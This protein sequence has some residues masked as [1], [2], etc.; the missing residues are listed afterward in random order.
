M[1]KN[2]FFESKG[3][4]KLNILFPKYSNSEIK[5]NDIKK[6]LSEASG[7]LIPGGFGKRGTEGKIAAI[8]YARKNNIPFLG[9]IIY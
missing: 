4:F 3:P 6:K 9:R 5:I 2:I 8:H 1:S 7:I